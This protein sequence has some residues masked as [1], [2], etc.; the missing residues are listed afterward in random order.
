MSPE[1]AF[2]GVTIVNFSHPLTEPQ[3]SAIADLLQQPIK[4]VI[5]IASQLDLEGDIEGQVH[6]MV[7]AS[8]LTSTEW[9]TTPLLI[10]PPAL[11]APSSATLAAI[12]GRTGYLPSVLLWR[13]TDQ[14]PPTYEPVHVINLQAVRDRARL[15]R[16]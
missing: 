14:T 9:Q 1:Q 7:D 15:S 2:D 13:R 16:D 3:R 6:R 8:G 5:D 10:N 12:A 4:R 11:A